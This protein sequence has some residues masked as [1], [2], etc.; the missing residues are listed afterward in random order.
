MHFIQREACG[1]AGGEPVSEYQFAVFDMKFPE[2]IFPEGRGER[3]G[4][5]RS[6]DGGDAQKNLG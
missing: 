5:Y 2:I 4:H 6:R 1:A 3:Q